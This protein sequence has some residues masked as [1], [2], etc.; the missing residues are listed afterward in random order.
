MIT[1]RRVF[2]GTSQASIAS[3]IL[4]AASAAG[5]SRARPAR[6]AACL[7]KDPEDRWQ[8]GVN[9]LHALAW[10]AAPF[11]GVQSPRAGARILPWALTAVVAVAFLVLAVVY[12]RRPVEEPRS[13][14]TVVLPEAGVTLGNWV[15]LSPDGRMLAYVGSTEGQ[16]RVWI[17]PLDALTARPL[18]EFEEAFNSIL[19]TRQPLPGVL[20][21]E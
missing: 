18:P 13:I 21:R 17:R 11:P 12:F 8:S 15:G 16:S 20:H 5:E 3:A 14:P 4:T 1:G 10:V 9:I 7:A 2:S 6:S 19:V